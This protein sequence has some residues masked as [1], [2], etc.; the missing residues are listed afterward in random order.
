MRTTI[1]NKT[2]SLLLPLT[3]VLAMLSACTADHLSAYVAGQ[4]VNQFVDVEE[5]NWYY[6][7]VQ[8][9]YG[10]GTVTP[11]PG[12]GAPAP[13]LYANNQMYFDHS[14]DQTLLR[15][16]LERDNNWTCI[17]T[18]ASHTTAVPAEN[19]QSNRDWLSVGS[20]VYHSNKGRICFHDGYASAEIFGDS[21]IIISDDHYY[22]YIT[23]E[24]SGTIIDIQSAFI[25]S[26]CLIVN[27]VMYRHMGSSSGDGFRLD[28]SYIFLGTVESVVPRNELPTENFQTNL[29][30]IYGGSIYLMPPDSHPSWDILV[31]IRGDH[32][33][34]FQERRN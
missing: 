30:N 18:I 12:T 16:I 9:I 26:A 19:F 11:A 2:L 21:L 4:D 28:N 15:E 27:D 23:R 17:G 34:Y 8:D 6:D 5:Y 31:H 29:A 25:F 33:V 7:A 3:M 14:A 1:K 20:E 22:Q 32:R 10:V 13:M 24:D